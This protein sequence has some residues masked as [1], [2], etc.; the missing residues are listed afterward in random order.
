[1]Y[2]QPEN[3]VGST[4]VTVVP[5]SSEVLFFYNQANDNQAIGRLTSSGDYV[6]LS[7][8]ARLSWTQSSQERITSCFLQRCHRG[9]ADRKVGRCRERDRLRPQLIELTIFA[10]TLLGPS[11]GVA[12]NLRWASATRAERKDSSLC[13]CPR[14]RRDNS[15]TTA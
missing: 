6:D 13:A 3:P 9:C 4:N 10:P 15:S 8:G 14:E 11:G 5:R 7:D 1:M 2:W 12:T